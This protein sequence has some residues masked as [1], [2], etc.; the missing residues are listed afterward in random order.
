MD[1]MD[2]WIKIIN[3]SLQGMFDLS[4]FMIGAGSGSDGEHE[5]GERSPLPLQQSG[6]VPSLTHE[7]G[8]WFKALRQDNTK[9]KSPE[10]EKDIE[11]SDWSDCEEASGAVTNKLTESKFQDEEP[12]ASC[13]SDG[14]DS[15]KLIENQTPIRLDKQENL[16]QNDPD[17]PVW[18]EDDLQSWSSNK[19]QNSVPLPNKNATPDQIPVCQTDSESEENA[20]FRQISTSPENLFKKS[21]RLSEEMSEDSYKPIQSMENVPIIPPTIPKYTSPEQ[22]QFPRPL[23][24]VSKTDDKSRRKI[25]TVHKSNIDKKI[26]KLRRKVDEFEASEALTDSDYTDIDSNDSE[27]SDTSNFEET[28]KKSQKL[29][30][31]VQREHLKKIHLKRIIA[32]LKEQKKNQRELIDDLITRNKVLDKDMTDSQSLL[33]QTHMKCTLTEDNL[34]TVKCLKGNLMDEIDNQS[35]IML[36]K[37]TEVNQLKIKLREAQIENDFLHETIEKYSGI[38]NSEDILKLKIDEAI[39]QTQTDF[40][41]KIFELEQAHLEKEK[42]WKEDHLKELHGKEKEYNIQIENLRDEQKSALINIEAEV[43][44]NLQNFKNERV[45]NDSLVSNITQLETEN[46][47]LKEKLEDYLTKNKLLETNLDEKIQE[48]SD[49]QAQ[50]NNLETVDSLKAQFSHMADTYEKKIERLEED[51]EINADRLSQEMSA[52]EEQLRDK[53]ELINHLKKDLGFIRQDYEERMKMREAQFIS[54]KETLFEKLDLMEQSKL[55]D[56]K[57]IDRLEKELKDQSEQIQEDCTL[58]EMLEGKSRECE[59]IG[60]ELSRMTEKSNALLDENQNLKANIQSLKQIVEKEKIDNR[61]VYCCAELFILYRCLF[62]KAS[63]FT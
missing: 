43:S 25:T 47:D 11:A 57:D 31:Y 54:E 37:M 17:S 60:Q 50:A 27:C 39:S 12:E 41:Q 3:V 30:G 62:L 32:K 34:N 45:K 63:S 14:G 9:M 38:D 23:P 21:N 49:L 4:R 48:I 44:A 15:Y 22:Q 24:R 18:S 61:L 2:P 55:N 6:D 52:N 35:S 26:E 40:N 7:E 33:Y 5:Q 29:R 1:F 36:E 42:L 19:N 20:K 13:W 10:P 16:Q 53:D 46:S 58:T 56:V 8:E 51:I 28:P 59:E